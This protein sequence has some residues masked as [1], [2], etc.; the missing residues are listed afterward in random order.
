MAAEE[1]CSCT[2]SIGGAT[3]TLLALDSGLRATGIVFQLGQGRWAGTGTARKNTARA[4]P[5][6]ASTVPVPG[7]AR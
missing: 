6:H 4:R 1:L 7:T 2:T 5:R 3:T